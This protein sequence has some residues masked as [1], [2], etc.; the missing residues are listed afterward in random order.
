MA[1]ADQPVDGD[2][3]PTD[4]DFDEVSVK[5]SRTRTW[6]GLETHPS[7]G[8][9]DSSDVDYERD[10]GNPGEYPYTRGGYPRMY[11]S[12]MWTLRNL[13]GY[14]APE[15]TRD[16]IATARAAGSGGIDVVVDTLTAEALDPDHPALGADVGLEGCSLPSVRDVERLLEDTDVTRT[17]VAW[18]TTM[19]IYPMVAA[20]ATRQGKPLDQIQGSH[21]PDHLQ[22]S[23]AGWGE[24]IMPADLAHRATI[25]CVEFASQH[26][27][28]WAL[29]L[30]QAYDLRERG[31]TPA[32]EIA[33]GMAI[34]NA[35]LE[36]LAERGVGVD[37][38][39]PSLAWVST[40]DIDL[41]E[42]V[43]K[44]RALRRV[45]ARTMKERFGA[46][47]PRSMRLRVACHTSGR[48][49][50]HQQP[51]NNLPRV[52]VEALA[53]LL[54]GV[55]SVDTCTYDE[56]V[57]IPTHEAREL[58]IRTQQIL[59]HEV[60][61]AR[62]ADPLGGSYYVESLT[63]QVE[64]EALTMLA[65]IEE[66]G[67]V[68]SVH[69]GTIEA[70]MDDY[71]MRLADE[72]DSGERIMVGVN[73]F[74]PANQE[75]PPRFQFDRAG[76]DTHIRRFVEMKATRDRALLDRRMDELYIAARGQHNPHQQMI[77][78]L[79][80]DASIAEV[81]GTVR[82]AQGYPYDPFG[83]IESPFKYRDAT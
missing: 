18:H 14:G 12:R 10:L 36:A 83:A 66:A 76:I 71:N 34:V 78:A 62:T 17:D 48:S 27:P 59:A 43:A 69:D 30:P 68:K 60:G 1:S 15:D 65:K 37:E 13:V 81:W 23:L 61:A 41:F 79:V 24:K 58:A 11:R 6:G 63:N 4:T 33:V 20:L 9:G 31:L 72:L 70:L 53:A 51:L 25:D 45:W 19:M 49:L 2:R 56:P 39:A 52:A 5:L 77:H 26:S 8:P 40:S 55:Q 64:A 73:R 7:Y 82:V 67:L 50:T 46:A 54:G 21:M 57:G 47:D 38:V 28:R 80:A 16:G 29:G 22:L 32:G 3:H 35:T 44:F 75:V 74:V 42:E